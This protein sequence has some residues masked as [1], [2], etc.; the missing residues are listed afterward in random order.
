[1]ENM[2]NRIENYQN[3][4]LSF[5]KTVVLFQEL[6][7]SGMLWCLDNKTCS[8]ANELINRGYVLQR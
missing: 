1:M 4:T 5:E 8:R 3:G 6:V 2:V 7:D